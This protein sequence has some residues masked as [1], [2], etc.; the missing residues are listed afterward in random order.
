M[1]GEWSMVSGEID[2]QPM[3]EDLRKS[4]KRVVKGGE[5]TVT[6]VAKSS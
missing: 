1:E 2:R 4:A 3:P 6:I 5:T